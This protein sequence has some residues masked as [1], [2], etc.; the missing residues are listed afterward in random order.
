MAEYDDPRVLL[1]LAQSLRMLEMGKP[2]RETVLTKLRAVLQQQPNHEIRFPETGYILRWVPSRAQ[3]RVRWFPLWL[4]LTIFMA[5]IVL[6]VRTY[7]GHPRHIHDLIN[8]IMTPPITLIIPLVVTGGRTLQQDVVYERGPVP[9]WRLPVSLAVTG[10]VILTA[11]IV[12]HAFTGR[13]SWTALILSTFGF[14]VCIWASN[15]VAKMT[16]IDPPASPAPQ[17]PSP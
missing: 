2:E 3:R 15:A 8:M 16:F 4:S 7:S 10:L 5:P 6:I 9:A 1:P 17:M 13:P 14:P 11:G 12:D